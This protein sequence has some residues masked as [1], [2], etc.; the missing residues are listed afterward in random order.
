MGFATHL[1]PWLLGTVK[2]TTGTTAGTISNT[3]CTIVA[4]TDDL[5]AAQ[6]ATGSGALGAIPAGALITSVQFITTTLFASATTL[7]VTIAGVDYAAAATIT[8]AG[9]YPQ[10]AAATFAPVAANV[11]ATDALVTFTATGSSV[12]GAVTVVIAYVVRDS[13]GSSAPTTYQN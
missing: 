7:K 10:T 11:G 5:T 9:V 3:G 4:Q 8:S 13:N 2:N 1:G 12:T 6:V